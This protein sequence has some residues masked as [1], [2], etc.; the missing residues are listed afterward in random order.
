MAH[1]TGHDGFDTLLTDTARLVVGLPYAPQLTEDGTAVLVEGGAVRVDLHDGKRSA[2]PE[3]PAA[4]QM[5]DVVGDLLGTSEAARNTPRSY[6]MIRPL[7]DPMP[8]VELSSPDGLW[9]ISTQAGDIELRSRVDGR[10]RRL[11]DDG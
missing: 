7:I 1:R 10:V 2:A 5:D 3:R 6:F 9:W 4:P 8:A 11:T